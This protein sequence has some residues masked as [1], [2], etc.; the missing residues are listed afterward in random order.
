[1]IGLV[2]ASGDAQRIAGAL[3]IAGLL[4]LAVAWSRLDGTVDLA[5]QV[6]PSIEACEAELVRGSAHMISLT[7]MRRPA[8]WSP[9]WT[10]LFLRLVTLLGYV[11]FT[12]GRLGGAPGIH[13]GHWHIIDNG[14][15]FLFC[16]NYDGNFGGYLDD[17]I[18]GAS[19]GTTLF[20]RWTKLK[21]RGPAAD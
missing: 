3:L 10:R 2:T 14:R 5:Q 17:F 4:A 1:T 21:P 20:W 13:F 18:N 6:H 9:W 8:P 12:E 19:T 11:I 7:D 16:S 15:R